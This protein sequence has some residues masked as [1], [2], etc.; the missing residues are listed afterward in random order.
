MA[1]MDC[2]ASLAV[3]GFFALAVTGFFAFPMT[4]IFVLND[5]G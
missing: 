2:H 3:T 5:A 4:G 1:V